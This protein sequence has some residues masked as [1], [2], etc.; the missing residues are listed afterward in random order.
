MRGFCV[1]RQ[2]LEHDAFDSKGGGVFFR[3]VFRGEFLCHPNDLTATELG[4]WIETRSVLSRVRQPLLCYLNA[5]EMCAALANFVAVSRPRGMIPHRERS[6]VHS[7]P[8]GLFGI[9]T[10]K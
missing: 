2:H 10:A 8:S 6:I 9:A 7:S 1:S 5:E 3:S 4:C